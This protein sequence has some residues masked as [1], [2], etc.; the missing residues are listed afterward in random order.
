MS[1]VKIA[2]IILETKDGKVEL[3]MDEAKD[4]YDQL[5]TLFGSKTTYFP[6]NPV[7]IDRDRWPYPQITCG[8]RSMGQIESNNGL[9]SPYSGTI[10]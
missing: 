10:L 9:P 1:K 5:H 2:K 6:S 7:V 4:L 8:T 3:S